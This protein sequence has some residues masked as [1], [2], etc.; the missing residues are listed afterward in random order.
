M[1]RI[2]ITTLLTLRRHDSINRCSLYAAMEEIN[3]P[4]KLIA[5]VKATMNNVELRYK[6]DYQNPL[7]LKAE[8]DKGMYWL[9]YCLM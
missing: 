2:H 1:E 5:L 4:Q 6:T 8:F 3:I 9:V 7:M